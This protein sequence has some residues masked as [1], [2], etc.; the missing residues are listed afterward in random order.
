M[1]NLLLTCGFLGLLCLQ[2]SA[3]VSVKGTVIDENQNGMIGATVV[4]LD[5]IDSSMINF[6]LS[7][8]AGNFEIEDVE[9]GE[10]ILQ[11]SY[12]S[13]ANQSLNISIEDDSSSFLTEEIKM[14]PS[15]EVLQE[16]TI[17]AEHIP[18]GIRGDTITYNASA[19]KTKPGASVED[20][21]R[22]MPGIEVARDG[23]I[24]AQGE[25]V[26]KVLVDG[27]EFFGDDPKIA[28][29]NLEAE[30]VDKVE[31]YDKQS[32]M[33]EFTGVDDGQEE[34][35]LNLKLKEDYKNGGFG[36]L[37]IA[38]GSSERY[39]TKLNYNRFSPSMQASILGASNNI[40]EQ[41]FSFNDYIG[42]MGGL[43]N[44]MS[45][46]NG[47]INFGGAF[48]GQQIVPRGL[49]QN[50]AAGLNFNYD[51]S[52]K[53]K[54]TSN[55]FYSQ[56]KTDV[57]EFSNS[58]QFT[59][60][61]EYESIDTSFSNSK[62]SNQRLNTKLDY[63]PNPLWQFV[64]TNN[65][66]GLVQQDIQSG[67]TIYASSMLQSRT[68]RNYNINENQLGYEG[69]VQ[70]RKKFLRKGRSLVASTSY[71]DAA[72]DERQDVLSDYF[73]N[74]WNT[75]L[76]QN[77]YYMNSERSFGSSVSFTEPVGAK[78]YLSIN[79]E[80]QANREKP[81]KDFYDLTNQ[82][83]VF[84]DSLSSNYQKRLNLHRTGLS[85]RNNG[86]KAKI[87]LGFNLQSTS[88]QGIIGEGQSRFEDRYNHF[89][90]LFDFDYELGR[91]QNLSINYDTDIFAPR[92]NQLM[93]LPDNSNPNIL[94]LGNPELIPEYQHNIRLAYNYID[95]F[96]F[97]S[98]FANFNIRRTKNRII[99]EVN[100]LEDFTRVIRPINSDAF[101]SYTGYLS[102]AQPLRKLGI[103]YRMSSRLGFT[104]YETYLN[105][106]ASQVNESNTNVSLTFENRKKDHVDIAAGIRFD[107][108]TRNYEVN[109]SFNQ[110]FFNYDLFIEWDFFLSKGFTVSGSFDHKRYSS[111]QF[112]EAQ[113]FNLMN[114]KIRKDL[115][116]GR[117]A[118]ELSVFD[119]LNQN[120]GLT[121]RGGINSL[122]ETSFNT[123]NQ[124]V[125]FGLKYRLGKRKKSGIQITD[126]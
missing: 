61:L 121:R 82:L 35:A 38:A 75:R 126:D 57:N 124:Y 104:Q 76:D 25:D 81:I 67:R 108:N 55:Y 84:N 98:L 109:S 114:I 87:N 71:S 36:N 53:L 88:L 97:R 83:E 86:K 28:T 50:H 58:Q 68:I 72:Y 113:S 111:E 122:N 14:S 74:Q 123:L 89:L 43:S 63:K 6:A 93:P 22:K 17:K 3:Q 90:P 94:I 117:L 37:E 12:V 1:K 120:I 9:L 115:L 118:F 70:L 41:A 91:S 33:A 15:N 105:D 20:L 73:F 116:S 110:Q 78:K 32:E 69:K 48:G 85:V 64:L 44:A 107:F 7:N 60:A 112:S 47:V 52:N 46:S 65:L 13:Y 23:S 29:Q 80:Y 40:N 10:Y 49:N 18:M 45:N 92:L 66:R 5:A 2:L 96:N 101:L 125:L 100:V 51:F 56:K 24:K 31:V 8:A 77:Q 59:Q 26:N 62:N 11:I 106:L 119:L 42:F 21:L 34:K 103:K 16:V 79:Y 30:A 54:W 99:N 95:R 4:L 39:K 102:W 19:F 27:K